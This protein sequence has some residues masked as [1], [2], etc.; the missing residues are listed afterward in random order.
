MLYVLTAKA[1]LDLV[2]RHPEIH[3]IV[4]QTMFGR[5]RADARREERRR[6]RKPGAILFPTFSGSGGVGTSLITANLASYV[7]EITH[8]KV[9]VLDLDLMFGDQGVVFGLEK[10]PSI[11]DFIMEEDLTLEIVQDAISPT[12]AGVDVLRAPLLPEQAE[13]VDPELI[14]RCLEL[15]RPAYDYIFIDTAKQIVD[16]TLDLFEHAHI[17]LYV[18]TPELLSVKN[19]TRWI[20]VVERIGLSVENL[21]LLIN[22]TDSDDQTP[23]D[24]VRKQFGDRV[25]DQLPFDAATAK[26][27]LNVGQVLKLSNPRSPLAIALRRTAG[28][29]VGLEVDSFSEQKSFWSR[30]L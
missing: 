20:S 28:K 25:L 27:S 5:F 7:A 21:K 18:L 14:S 2:N 6:Q 8:K 16:L 22:K 26:R 11:S 13:F 15:L 12:D 10:G 23:A 4:N 1:F 9:L 24:F 3:N 17:P 19:A 29:L 30:W